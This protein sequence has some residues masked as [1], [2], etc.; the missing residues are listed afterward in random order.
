[1][2]VT[3][4]EKGSTGGLRALARRLSYVANGAHR[5]EATA[6]AAEPLQA[7]VKAEASEH[8]VSGTLRDTVAVEPG[9]ARLRVVGPRYTRFVKGLS[10]RGG[11]R[12]AQLVP[13]LTEYVRVLRK[14]I[15]G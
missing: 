4:S 5:A 3:V 13:A 12:R 11:L 9:D 6:A 1:V 7:L 8:V 15:L 2:T 10:Y 14:A